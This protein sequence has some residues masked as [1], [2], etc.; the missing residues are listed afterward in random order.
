M[1][2]ARVARERESAHNLAFSAGQTRWT[3]ITLVKPLAYQH[4]TKNNNNN[5]TMM[6]DDDD[7]SANERTNERANDNIIHC[8]VPAPSVAL[9]KFA[10]A[11]TVTLLLL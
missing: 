7:A 3:T 6:N 4:T 11:P 5:T 8:H 10:T 1:N 2:T 9:H